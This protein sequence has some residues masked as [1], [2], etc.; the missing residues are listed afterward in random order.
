MSHLTTPRPNTGHFST[1]EVRPSGPSCGQTS[2][3]IA[4]A[5]HHYTD[6]PNLAGGFQMLD[7]QAQMRKGGT[8]AVR[9]NIIGSEISASGFRVG[10]EAWGGAMMRAAE[11][12]WVE[13]K[14]G[15]RGCLFGQFDT[16]SLREDR[17]GQASAER[18]KKPEDGGEVKPVEAPPPPKQ[19][20]SKR[21]MFPGY[22]TGKGPLVVI[23]WLNR[24]DLANTGAGEGTRHFRLR[25][26]A[27]DVTRT[28]LTARIETWGDG[29]LAGAAMCWIALPQSKRHVTCG[30][31][32]AEDPEG[33][34][35][36]FTGKVKF[37]KGMFERPPKVV[38]ALNMFD[39]KA[40]GRQNALR[41]KVV[42]EDLDVKGFRWRLE[43]WVGPV[44]PLASV[45][46]IRGS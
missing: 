34:E 44:L 11:V 39:V 25:A 26:E 9:A 17:G 12:A 37:R 30:V 40:G 42:M 14:R 2:R 23:C 21:F 6:P 28:G 4:F 29:V 3:N 41:V 1:L 43:T 10:V 31:F 13:C 19:S 16:L 33:E 38:A 7:L 24:L 36:G 18:L 5:A 32:R 35:S 22:F 27:L 45:G 15:A 46:H 8:G 20:Y